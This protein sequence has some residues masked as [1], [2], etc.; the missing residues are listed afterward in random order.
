MRVGHIAGS[1]PKHTSGLSTDRANYCRLTLERRS[2]VTIGL[3]VS[4]KL[5]ESARH[6]LGRAVTSPC[7][8]EPCKA[9]EHAASASA[10]YRGPVAA[11]AN[12][13]CTAAVFLGRSGRSCRA[14][15]GCVDVAA[16]P[17]ATPPAKPVAPRLD[18]RAAVSV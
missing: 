12:T 8:Q 4:D 14:D 13:R 7:E 16:P 15:L 2:S 6:R 17:C 18:R 3:G 9:A 11:M 5:C 1:S 10:Q